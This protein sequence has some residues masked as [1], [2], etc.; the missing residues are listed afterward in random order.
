M[1][2]ATP[3]PS[4]SGAPHALARVFGRDPHERGRASTPLELL[5]DLTA[6][7]AFGQAGSGFAHEVAAGDIAAASG[8]Y[9]IACFAIWWAWT[10]FSWYA[11]AFDTDDWAHRGLTMVQMVGVVVMAL[12]FP[13]FIESVHE[14]DPA[15]GLMVA[16]YVVMRVAMVAQW[17]RV[18]K[19]SPFRRPAVLV[20][21]VTLGIQVVWTYTAVAHLSWA[22]FIAVAAVMC[23]AEVV[24]PLAIDRR[25]RFPWHAE[26]M[27]ERYSLLAI[28]TLGEGVIGTVAAL[29]SAVD[30]H[31]GWTLDAVAVVVAGIVLTFGLWWSYF[32][33]A[34]GRLLETVRT[35]VWAFVAFHF[36][37]IAGLAATGAG[38]HVAGYVLAGEAHISSTLA[39]A[40][41]SVPV[42]AAFCGKYGLYTVFVP[43]ADW[44][45]IILLTFTVGILGG[46]IALAAAGV[47]TALCLAVLM[48]APLPTIVGYEWFG[49][50]HQD[51]AITRLKQREAQRG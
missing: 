49:H 32:T 20:A 29:S 5:Y 48:L 6:A 2:S 8:A 24:F 10:S 28:I 50:D 4:R 27:A 7:V 34:F 16:G 45:H 39:V 46:S 44:R 12:G 30:A 18:E 14:P 35:K 36:L 37:I 51:A 13:H 40:V 43:E 1:S 17:L 41:L 15:N 31:G 47:P 19:A 3:A 23:L 25:Y 22:S 21:L 38:L 11:S 33:I 26:H 9:L 42:L